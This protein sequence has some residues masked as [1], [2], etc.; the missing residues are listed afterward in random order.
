MYE[1][2]QCNFRL[3]KSCTEFPCHIKHPHHKNHI[4]SIQPYV[5]HSLLYH[6]PFGFCLTSLFDNNVVVLRCTEC[7][8]IEHLR[9]ALRFNHPLCKD[10]LFFRLVMDLLLDAMLVGS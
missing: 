6:D 9:C 5:P 1:C 8:Y 10:D 4:L 3:H 7:D 2:T